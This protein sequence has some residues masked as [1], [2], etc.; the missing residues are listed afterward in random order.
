LK[1]VKKNEVATEQAPARGRCSFFSIPPPKLDNIYKQITTIQKKSKEEEQ[2]EKEESLN[3]ELCNA[4]RFVVNYGVFE[5]NFE[6]LPNEVS[7]IEGE[8]TLNL[9]LKLILDLFFF[10]ITQSPMCAI[11]L[12]A[13]NF[14][15]FSIF[16][17]SFTFFNF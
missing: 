16:S 8:I 14:V 5:A 12:T 4:Y 13:C 3:D 1:R 7:T 15:Y 2:K 9:R 6:W 10:F 11:S 17:S